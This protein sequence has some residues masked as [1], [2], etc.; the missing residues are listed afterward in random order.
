MAYVDS[1]LETN[2]G[3]YAFEPTGGLLPMAAI[4]IPTPRDC[5]SHSDSG[6]EF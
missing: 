1:V 2:A 5:R 4:M 3:A 6:V